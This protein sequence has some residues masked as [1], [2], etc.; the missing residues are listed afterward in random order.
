MTDALGEGAGERDPRMVLDVEEVG[1][2]QVCV[3]VGLTGP[4]P[5]RVDVALKTR[6]HAVGKV[7]VQLAAHVLE[8][9]A[10]PG[11]HHVAGTELRFRVPWLKDP[12]SHRSRGGFGVDDQR[13]STKV[14][15]ARPDCH[16]AAVTHVANSRHA[17]GI[18]DLDAQHLGRRD[19][20]R[21]RLGELGMVQPSAGSSRAAGSG[22]ASSGSS[23]IVA[24]HAAKVAA[25]NDHPS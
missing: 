16:L 13:A 7:K 22:S 1:A 6:L 20:L 14:L 9:P 15:P 19:W 8:E 17:F 23:R 5:G 4:D 21:Q 10:D 24:R 25:S 12:L 3:A 2:A 18:S 11:D